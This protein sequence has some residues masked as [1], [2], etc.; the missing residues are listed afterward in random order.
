[1]DEAR[2]YCKSVGKRLPR[3]EEWQFAATGGGEGTQVYPWGDSP[4]GPDMVPAQVTGTVFPGP[5]HVGKHPA[6]AS[7][8]GIQDLIGNVWQ[9]TDEYQDTHTR[10]VILRGGANYRPSSSMWYFPMVDG[11]CVA[12]HCGWTTNQIHNK[13]FLMNSRYVS[14]NHARLQTLAAWDMRQRPYSRRVSFICP[15]INPTPP[16]SSLLALSP[17]HLG[18]CMPCMAHPD[19]PAPLQRCACDLGRAGAGRHRRLPVRR[20]RAGERQS[21]LRRQEPVRPISGAG[22]ERHAG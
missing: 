19:R 18:A 4:P 20:G 22:C 17:A 11:N 16:S 12:G 14:P 13:Y 21:G 1:M 5:E 15:I 7:P 6:G 10:S 8:F 2:S 9:M 3:E